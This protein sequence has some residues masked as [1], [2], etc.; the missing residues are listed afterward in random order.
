MQS[1]Y[2]ALCSSTGN[3][4]EYSIEDL[5]DSVQF[6]V[7]ATLANQF[8]AFVEAYMYENYLETLTSDKVHLYDKEQ[9]LDGGIFTEYKDADPVPD[10]FVPE[11]KECIG[12]REKLN[13][14]TTVDITDSLFRM[15]D[16]KIIPY[17]VYKE[18]RGHAMTKVN[19]I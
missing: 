10:S 12:A 16:Q 9:L 15:L 2:R 14:V 5:D 11:L 4:G 3:S 6:I 8:E 1:V 13:I 7:R 18:S 19:N 17:D